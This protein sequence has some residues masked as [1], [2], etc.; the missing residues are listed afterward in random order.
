MGSPSARCAS[1][2]P[3]DALIVVH[4]QNDF[5]DERSADGRY[6]NGENS[7]IPPSY[8]FQH[9][10]SGMIPRGS[11]AVKGSEVVVPVVNRYLSEF[12]SRGAGVFVTLDW[13]PPGHCSFCRFGENQAQK[14]DCTWGCESEL[15]GNCVTGAGVPLD[16]F[17]WTSHCVDPISENAFQNSQLLLWPDHGVEGTFGARLDPFLRVPEKAQFIKVGYKL[18]ED[19]YDTLKGYE[20]LNDDTKTRADLLTQRTLREI[21]QSGDYERIFVAG[22]AT[23]MVVKSTILSMLESE[24]GTGD[25]GLG[26][27][28]SVVLLTSAGKG[29]FDAP[30]EYYGSD[31]TSLSAEVKRDLRAKGAHLVHATST[32]PA[33]EELCEGTCDTD[34]QCLTA[35]TFCNKAEELGSLAYMCTP[36]PI[37]NALLRDLLMGASLM[38]IVVLGF[39]FQSELVMYTENRHK[40]ANPPEGKIIVVET[41]IEGSSAI[42]EAMSEK[43]Q[44]GIM[45]DMVMDVHDR[46]MRTCIAK[47]FG[48]ELYV[49]GDAFVIGFHNVLDAL[50]FSMDVQDMLLEADW[51][52]ELVGLLGSTM[53]VLGTEGM[54]FHGLRVRMGIHQG[55]YDERVTKDGKL[56]Y[57]GDVM[58]QATSVADSGHGGQILLS[59][60]VLP[61]PTMPKDC[62]I[63]D[64][65]IHELDNFEGPTRLVEVFRENLAPRHYLLARLK[66]KQQLTPSFNQAPDGEVTVVFTGVVGLAD[67]MRDLPADVVENA[68]NNVFRK[69]RS[70]MFQFSGYDCRGAEPD[71][72]NLYAF[73]HYASAVFFSCAAQEAMLHLPWDQAILDHPAAKHVTDEDGNVLFSGFRLKMGMHSGNLKRIRIPATGRADYY[74]ESANR[75]ARVA[76]CG[77]GGQVVCVQSEAVHALKETKLL[78]NSAITGAFSASFAAE[79][80]EVDFRR[81]PRG[82]PFDLTLEPMGKFSLKGIPGLVALT[83]VS[84]PALAERTKGAFKEGAKV[85]QVHGPEADAEPIIF[86]GDVSST[87][88]KRQSSSTR[89]ASGQWSNATRAVLK[90]SPLSE[91]NA[92]VKEERPESDVRKSSAMSRL[93]AA[94]KLGIFSKSQRAEGDGISLVRID[95]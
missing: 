77:V 3:R 93:K 84:I 18:H 53:D 21:I 15:R 72:N 85:K 43:G 46:V 30:G 2:G 47:H 51:P 55:A 83:Q 7:G 56:I 37:V 90:S 49:R 34:R 57:L 82:I 33:L 80:A 75:A 86:K 68:L 79:A 42:W 95:D 19:E 74:G 41:D 62:C 89:R 32:D 91:A 44:A 31:P 10:E 13:H 8:D 63:F 40:R 50:S 70:V 36:K 71:G 65:G 58:T 29:V 45:K 14:L 94:F 26:S 11:L 81:P 39:F 38:G 67:M 9:S 23:D 24:P 61:L 20:A 1:V 48:W 76:A 22:L 35:G 25:T 52:S 6:A 4:M 60:A 28:R 88:A 27:V 12:A 87:A 54:L 66:T 92:E 17:N 69:L 16:I 64:M 73:S 59:Q 5:L 78:A